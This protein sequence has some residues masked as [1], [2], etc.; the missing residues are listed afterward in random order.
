MP[1]ITMDATTMDPGITCGYC[2]QPVQRGRPRD[3]IYDVA[4]EY[5]ASA[6]VFSCVADGEGN[7]KTLPGISHAA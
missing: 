2:H 3:M 5:G 1:A 6:D 7:V 4:F